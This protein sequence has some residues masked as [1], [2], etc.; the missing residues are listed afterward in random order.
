M[1]NTRLAW[2]VRFSLFICFHAEVSSFAFFRRLLY[3]LH[4]RD[5]EP[6][7]AMNDMIMLCIHAQILDLPIRRI[8]LY[9]P[10]FFVQ[11]SL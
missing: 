11:C 4:G 3:R 6:R 10:Q 8:S 5:F 1:A 7:F 9:T 2:L